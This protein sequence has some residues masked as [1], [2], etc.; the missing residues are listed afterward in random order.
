[1]PGP[2]SG[3]TAFTFGG[4]PC[5]GVDLDADAARLHPPNAVSVEAWV[6]TRDARALGDVLRA[7]DGGYSLLAGSSG[8]DLTRY[9]RDK[10]QHGVG[11]VTDGAWH[12]LVGTFGADGYH[13]YVDGQLSSA[14]PNDGALGYFGSEAAIGRDGHA[15][16]GV[17]PS[18]QGGIA[19]VAVYPAVLTP[20]QVTAHYRASG[21]V[22]VLDKYVALGDSYSSG[23]GLYTTF[24]PR[25]DTATDSCHRSSKAYSQVMSPRADPFVACSGVTTDA[26]WD[27]R[28]GEPAQSLALS[29]SDK[30]VTM[31]LGGNNLGW[32]D[33]LLACTKLER[34]ITHDVVY[35]DDTGCRRTLN[36]N[37]PSNST[38]ARIATM[39]AR[40]VDIYKFTMQHAPNAQV[41]VLTYPPIFPT[42]RSSGGCR[43]E[44][45]NVPSGLSPTGLQV[46]IAADVE[47]QFAAYEQQA[48]QAIHDAVLQVAL[49]FPGNRLKV[50]D[51]ESQFGGYG[52]SGHTVSC[53]DTGRPTPWINSIRLSASNVARLMSDLSVS[54]PGH[55]NVPS[56][57]RIHAG[58][59][60]A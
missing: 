30:L 58:R 44:R 35:S 32:T 50:V 55:I 15:C 28:K 34:Q 13:L 1:M 54:T 17:V 23:E 20:D 57:D 59:V 56:P 7:R 26:F 38:A 39:K 60:S 5:D 46:V 4:G 33:I 37:T 11:S 12:Y 10:T 43:I 24:D 45:I 36:G 27:S 40:L 31:T 3:T 47:K 49:A 16:D 8:L 52:S 53:G 18:F 29:S 42:V 25:T 9:P 48:N 21:V 51:V 2:I 6:N 14:G 41:R 22:P 19:D